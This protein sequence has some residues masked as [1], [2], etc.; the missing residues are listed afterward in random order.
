MSFVLPQVL[1]YQQFKS[2]PAE[3]SEPLRT[4]IVGPEYQLHRYTD[5][6][7]KSLAG[8]WDTNSDMEFTW[9]NLEDAEGGTVDLNYTKVYLEN[10]LLNY[11][12]STDTAVVP[13]GET[14][15]I[16]LNINIVDK[17]GYARNASLLRDVKAGDVAIITESTTTVTAN[18]LDVEANLGTPTAGSVNAGSS[19]QPSVV[20]SVSG[21]WTAGGSN[22]TTNTVAHAAGSTYDAID[23]GLVSDTYTFT[24]VQSGTT[25]TAK[26]D[27]TS[28]SGLD[29]QYGVTFS[30]LTDQPIGTKG[31]LVDITEIGA[32]QTW[33]VGDSFSATVAGYGGS[34]YTAPSVTA[35]NVASYDGDQDT[36]YIVTVVRAGD[37]TSADA[38]SRP[39]IMVTTDNGYDSMSPFVLP[40]GTTSTDYS[41]GNHNITIRFSQ[42]I[43]VK[44]DL[45][46]VPITAAPEEEIQTIVLDTTLPSAITGAA[47]IDSV[48]LCI[49][50]SSLFLNPVADNT[51]NWTQDASGITI[52]SSAVEVDSEWNSGET[53]LPIIGG[54]IYLHWR[55]L[56]DTHTDR[57]YTV[58]TSGDLD[59]LFS[60]P[61]DPDNPLYYAV[62]KALTNSGSSSSS[63][64]FIKFIGVASDDVDGYTTALDKSEGRD[65]IYAIVP[66]TFDVDVQNLVASHISSLSTPEIGQWRIGFI[67]SEEEDPGP[68]VTT[69][70]DGAIVEGT[71]STTGS[72]SSTRHWIDL[73]TTDLT[74]GA[75]T[76]SYDL[77]NFINEGAEVGDILR[78]NYGTDVHG[79]DT[80]ESYT[81]KAVT[82]GQKLELSSGPSTV[83]GVP[84]RIEVWRALSADDA[85]E[86]I[87][88]KANAFSS[89]RIYNIY[90]STIQSDGEMVP[91]Y[92]LAAAIAGL[93]GGSAP[94]QGLTN[95]EIKGFDN[96]DNVVNRFSRTQLDTLANYGVWIVTHDVQNGTVYTRRQLST[97]T[98]DLNTAELSV[99]KNVDSISYLIRK[100]LSRF[101]GKTNVTPQTLETMRTE[102]QAAI[103]YLIGNSGPS[104]GGQVLP[105]TTIRE[106]RPHTLLRDRVVVILDLIIPYPLNNIEAY[107]VV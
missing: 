40:Q 75:G 101:I 1:V 23:I 98:T 80:Y 8:T 55:E 51:T 12:T 39:K 60:T 88:S 37:I 96:V 27:V 33:A 61:N 69:K 18:I 97:N 76:S 28:A 25:L 93:V 2:L 78:I 70:S 59:S 15:K 64:A 31:V 21:A 7:E 74:S 73:N 52:S 56:V 58:E 10:A 71:Y 63:S 20:A 16:N 32:T 46:T 11:Y 29:D 65:D 49:K 84:V 94:Q 34:D 103:D 99:V 6:D 19:N 42:N 72:G 9:S 77:V 79:N 50:K 68:I 83:T 57:I 82:S 102:V 107:I 105:G 90:P 47:T 100:R 41:I 86:Q 89:S 104:I 38:D 85:V 14:N 43:L 4:F 91:G 62:S 24:C 92:Y 48:K 35:G 87:G 30:G 5:S 13:S 67:C 66:L 3:L 22:A 106:L 45:W 26:F 54:D 53:G 95:V 81:I 17:S 36:T 44:N